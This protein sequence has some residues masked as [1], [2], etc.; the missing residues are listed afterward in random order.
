MGLIT[1]KDVPCWYRLSWLAEAPAILLRIHQDMMGIIRSIQPDAPIV[2]Y[3]QKELELGD[4]TND[5]QAE[6]GFNKSLV[7]EDENNSFITLRLTLP[8]S[9]QEIRQTCSVCRGSDK[10]LFGNKCESCGGS[11]DEHKEYRDNWQSLF[12]ASAS[13]TI[14]FGQLIYSKKETSASFPQLLT[15]ETT[16]HRGLHGGTLGGRYSKKLVAWLSSLGI[17]V[18]IPEMIQAMKIAY[19]HMV[20]RDISGLR[21][22]FKAVVAYKN[23]WLNVSCPGNACGLNPEHHG[24]EKETGYHW[25]CHNVDGPIQ[26]LTLIAGLAALCDRAT[27][28]LNLLKRPDSK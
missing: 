5:T 20:T 2:K 28:D 25:D 27:E 14:L 6:F 17:N 15:I 3:F 26:Q 8:V 18:Q 4:F 21:N 24:L 12:A 22:Q 16:T 11:G 19:E 10:D 9:R 13:L 23:G 1:Y 7:A